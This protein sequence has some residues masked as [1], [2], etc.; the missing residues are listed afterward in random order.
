[1]PPCCKSVNIANFNLY[2]FQSHD[3]GRRWSTA[4]SLGDQLRTLPQ[5]PAGQAC[6]SSFRGW[7]T[8][9]TKSKLKIKDPANVYCTL[10]FAHFQPN[11]LYA[12]FRLMQPIKYD[13][14]I[15]LNLHTFSR[16]SVMASSM[17]RN[18]SS[19]LI[20]IGTASTG[21]EKLN[22]QTTYCVYC[23][24][25]NFLSV[26]STYIGRESFIWTLTCVLWCYKKTWNTG[27]LTNWF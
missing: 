3:F 24:Y 22:F 10:K 12:R 15:Y 25:P 2:V 21:Q 4:Q 6:S 20:E 27:K 16:V 13:F 7:N 18:P 17:A 14:A 11:L 26:S 1:M 8:R 9:K 5:H 23:I 19:S